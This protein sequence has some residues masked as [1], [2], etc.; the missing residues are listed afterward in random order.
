MASAWDQ[1]TE[2]K[3]KVC[4][5]Q[6]DGDQSDGLSGR[7]RHIRGKKGCKRLGEFVGGRTGCHKSGKGDTDLDGGEELGRLRNHLVQ[8]GGAL[9]AV[10]RHFLSLLS[11]K[12]TMAISLI[13]KKALMAMSTRRMTICKIVLSGSIFYSF[14]VKTEDLIRK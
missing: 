3:V 5:Q 11:L 8:D 13:A 9:V 12:V 1:L 10:L 2:N 4:Q 6:G 7:Q 14:F